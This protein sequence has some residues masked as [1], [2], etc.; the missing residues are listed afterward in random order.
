MIRIVAT[1]QVKP[2]AGEKALGLFNEL[3]EKSRGDAGCAGYDLVRHTTDQ[4]CYVMLEA[5]ESQEQLDQH[6]ASE[7]FT[8]LVP[9]LVGLCEKAPAIDAYVQVL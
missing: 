7:H 6:S 8:R 2:G 9:Q 5:W 4:N 3:V 1:F